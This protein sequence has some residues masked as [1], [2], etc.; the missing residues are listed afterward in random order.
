[1]SPT[2]SRIKRT[3][4][5]LATMALLASGLTLL[6]AA[7]ANA[8]DATVTVTGN[9]IRNS[10]AVYEGWHEGYNNAERQYYV[11]D[12][13]L[14]LGIN[15]HSQILNGT[16]EVPADADT[17]LAI[18][19][20][21]ALQV[22]SGTPTFQLPLFFGTGATQ[23]YATL[24]PADVVVGTNTWTATSN[25]VSSRDI[26][27]AGTPVVTANTPV[28]LSDIID[29]MRS[30]GVLRLLGY[31]VQA[32]TE[33]VV[34]SLTYANV[35][36]VFEPYVA[37]APGV[38]E[39]V[40]DVDLLG[41]EQDNPELDG[42]NYEYW[43]EG[44]SV[45]SSTV[46]ADGLNLGS[47]EASTTI[48]GTTVKTDANSNVVTQAE[49]QQ[50]ITSAS[51]TVTSG[52]TNFQVPVNFSPDLGNF[53]TLL[54]ENFGAGTHTFSLTDTWR[55]SRAFGPYAQFQ[56]V[57]LGDLLDTLYSVGGGEVW[58]A[59]FGVQADSL[60]VVPSLV[61]DGTEYLFQ[62]PV[63]SACTA[64]TAAPVPTNQNS[65][66]WTFGETRA[67][68]HNEF[69]DGG[70]HVWTEGATST[71]KAAGYTAASFPL[72][73]VGTGFGLASTG[74]GVAP[75][76]LQLMV[77]LNN[78][79]LPEGYLVYEPDSYGV[80]NVWLSSNWNGLDLTGAPTTIN[81]GGTG[82]GGSVNDWLKIWPDAQILAVGYSLG[83]G[84]LGDW[85]ITGITAGCMTYGFTSDDVYPTP[86]STVNVDDSQIVPIE[87]HTGWGDGY[88][89]TP[90]SYSTQADGAH[91][92]DGYRTQLM[93]NFATPLTTTE[94][95]SLIS[96]ASVNVV[97]GDIVTYQIAILYGD[98]NT[99]TTLRSEYLPT[100]DN[101]FSVSDVW[102][103]TKK[104]TLNDGSDLGVP[105]VGTGGGGYRLP[106]A[107]MVAF[108]NA[109][110]NVRILGVGVQSNDPAVVQDVVFNGTKYHFVPT[111]VTAPTN[112]VVVPEAS[113][114]L[115]EPGNYTDW[116][117]GYANDTKSFSVDL[118]GLNLGSPL[119]SQILK[120][121]ETPVDAAD[122]YGL[123]TSQ[124]GVTVED[125]GVT[126]QVAV[127][128]DGGWSTLR[129]LGLTAGSHTFS[130]SDDWQSSKP[131]GTAILAN[132][133]Y[134]LGDILDALN[135]E[136]EAIA[137]GFGVQAEAAAQVSSITWGD[138]EYTFVPSVTAATPT[139]TGTPLV[140]NTLTAEG[141]QADWVP[142]DAALAYQWN[143]N[144]SAIVGADDSTYVLTAS[145]VGKTI[146]VTVT[147]T[148]TGYDSASATSLG[149]D[150]VALPEIV[151]G[152]PTISGTAEVG[153]T[154]TADPNPD[155]WTPATG[156]VFAYQWKVGGTDVSGAT[157]ST[158]TIA[159][160]DLDK[161]VSVTVTGTKTDYIGDSAT[162]TAVGPVANGD[163]LTTRISG[164]DRYE[165]AAEIAKKWD[166]ASIVFIAN[167]LGFPDALSAGPAAAY[168]DAPLL[169]TAPNAL[170]AA[171]KTQLLRLEPSQ[172][173][174]VGGTG[175]VSAAVQDELEGLAFSPEVGRIG[176][177][178][179]YETSRLLV[180]TV[181]P[182]G[183]IDTAY[184]ANGT[185]FPDALTASPAAAHFGG[186]VILVP[187]AA[188]SVDA[189]TISLMDKLGVDT[190]KVAGGTG[191]ISAAIV[192]QLNTKY[193]SSNVTRNGGA[194]RYA[195][196]VA[197]NGDEFTSAETVYVATGTGFADALAGAALAGAERAPLFVSQPTCIPGA[198]LDAIEDL[199]AIN[200]VLLGG[201]GV[202]ST[203][204]ADLTRCG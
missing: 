89:H 150:P 140:G 81:G 146:T 149:T 152:T 44:K 37:A 125:G 133:S 132:T 190:V 159:A 174:I 114:E 184:L 110:G 59:G 117:E 22:V 100:G 151:A 112:E 161:V 84:V 179:R 137:I 29:A 86:T 97:D 30:Q 189:A 51:F 28:P 130:L 99:F 46:K 47:P 45:D 200:V 196:A 85:T 121:L 95:E 138:T 68:G 160:A 115:T 10:E 182:D 169:L 116:H 49:L 83:S 109:Q 38:T 164:S 107:D 178:D 123:L 165:T 170:S 186:P 16:V 2:V 91:I 13:G 69:V 162:S 18:I 1:M 103:S 88:G 193:G 111:G 35:E 134:P 32:E 40:R 27:N 60:S 90:R 136:D 101:N 167:G 70:L 185:N 201:T 94:L 8:V 80:N 172:I 158:Y 26:P 64:T 79:T 43:H 24:R 61:W 147:G 20:Q 139:I 93:N 75:P 102:A 82:L 74:T 71:D 50:L 166:S 96:S 77:D 119:H 53:V 128:W 73:E 180:D 122:L 41:P 65:Q 181:F 25:W 124:A 203:G 202:L 39:V 62:Q 33:A 113:I 120:G 156:L 118:D 127:D 105:Y 135:A 9:D 31:G 157:S 198:V 63:V 176:G 54:S 199:G 4:S 188:G 5:G 92:G 192:S 58:L 42:F 15:D 52:S 17:L 177:V 106:V 154:L 14:H 195:T 72:S 21:S 3:L 171:A 98:L 34:S 76:S 168:L 187:G 145:E 163:V 55:V 108:L 175:V 11:A 12:D 19:E 194:D 56:E 142:A 66:G 57:A 153:Q 191:S 204:V 126:Y 197:I 48:H 131:I 36:Y 148:K 144:G 129:S 87:D 155:T 141:H 23:S 6:A 7:P 67:T 183:A 143:A 78:D 104:Y 173:V